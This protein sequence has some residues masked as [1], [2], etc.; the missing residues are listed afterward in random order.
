MER[1]RNTGLNEELQAIAEIF[2]EGVTPRE[3]LEI[4]DTGPHELGRNCFQWAWSAEHLLPDRVPY[5]VLSAAGLRSTA[6]FVSALSEKAFQAFVARYG[7]PQAPALPTRPDDWCPW[8]VTELRESASCRISRSAREVCSTL[9]HGMC[10]S[11]PQQFFLTGTRKRDE[12]NLWLRWQD[13][14]SS[15]RYTTFAASVEARPS[16]SERDTALL[17]LEAYWGTMQGE[18]KYD[19]PNE[20]NA[21]GP[22]VTLDEVLAVADRVWPS[23]A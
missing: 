22:L 1:S 16:L 23:R 14:E 13:H 21:E 6:A 5:E 7:L 20:I 11:F 2:V 10:T 17:L 8:V 18:W 12:W 4:L 9:V 19:R 15:R 3:A